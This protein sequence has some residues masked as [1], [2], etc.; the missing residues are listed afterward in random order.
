V[1]QWAAF[2]DKSCVAE[3]RI[4]QSRA[5]VST[6]AGSIDATHACF[7]N[8]VDIMGDALGTIVNPRSPQRVKIHRLDF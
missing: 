3:N 6:G 5:T 1:K 2:W 8:A 4:V 7:D